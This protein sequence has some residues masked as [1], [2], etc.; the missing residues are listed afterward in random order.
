[1][2][3]APGDGWE[4]GVDWEGWLDHR[5]IR[6]RLDQGADPEA[7]PCGERPL[8]RAVSFGSPEVVA[9]LAGRVTD[10]DALEDGT[11]ALWEAVVG[12]RPEIA[13]VLVAAG[14]DPWR[15]VLAGW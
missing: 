15:P 8:H 1:M 14:A 4:G 5:D 10:V 7:L 6:R 13:R 2:G 3:T 11:T 12:H 9:E